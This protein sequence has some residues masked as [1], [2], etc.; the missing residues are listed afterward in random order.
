[1]MPEIKKYAS[2]VVESA[3]LE[4]VEKYGADGLVLCIDAGW[5][6]R[7]QARECSIYCCVGNKIVARAHVQKMAD[8]EALNA[9]ADRTYVGAS[10]GM[11]VEG[12]DIIMQALSARGVKVGGLVH[13]QDTRDM[14]VV[15]KYYPDAREYLDPGHVGKNIKKK[16]AALKI[17]QGEH[18]GRLY[19]WAKK[20]AKGDKEVFASLWAGIFK[21][22]QG[23]HTLCTAGCKK[24][25]KPPNKPWSA[26]KLAK[27]TKYFQNVRTLIPKIIHP[28][29]TNTNESLNNVRTKFVPKRLNC[30]LTFGTRADMVCLDYN[31]GPSWKI[32]LYRRMGLSV[33][34]ELKRYVRK[35]E[36]QLAKDKVRKLKDAFKIKR[37]GYKRRRSNIETKKATTESG[38]VG[39]YNSKGTRDYL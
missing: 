31:V 21:H 35:L 30:P 9:A 17:G 29:H 34:P 5:S 19:F 38:V 7:R 6:S 39:E 28:Y 10:Q 13:D 16:V 32:E 12:S 25:T 11:E 1:M 14:D 37:A 26:D 22:I 33:G 4:A 24:E 8:C 27:V 15:R 23:D 3:L 36:R 2:E 20:K 18:V